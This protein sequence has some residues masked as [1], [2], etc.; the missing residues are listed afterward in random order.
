MISKWA[1]LITSV[2]LITHTFLTFHATHTWIF[3]GTET[4][5]T[6]RDPDYL[7]SAFTM[8]QQSLVNDDYGEKEVVPAAKLLEVIL[9]VHGY[10]E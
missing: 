9:Q 3:R 4:F 6:S 1:D 10:G 7:A 5:L 8:V 2:A